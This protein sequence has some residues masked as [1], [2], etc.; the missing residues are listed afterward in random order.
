L[1]IV[2]NGLVNVTRDYVLQITVIHTH[3]SSVTVFTISLLTASNGGCS[4]FSGFVNCP[5]AS[6]IA[7]TTLLIVAAPLHS[8]C[9]GRTGN[10]AYSSS[11]IVGRVRCLAMDPVLLLM[12]TNLLPSNGVSQLFISQLLS[13]KQMYDTILTN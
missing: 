11:Y 5:R 6:D 2:F 3:V 9:T 13:S 1:V 12:F 8:L 10:T 7:T 4:L